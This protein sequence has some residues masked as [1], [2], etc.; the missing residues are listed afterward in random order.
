MAMVVGKN[1]GV[2]RLLG[3]R[4]QEVVVGVLEE[5]RR[6]RLG[7]SDRDHKWQLRLR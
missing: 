4:L 3:P 6:W 7:L 2:T 1:K 5:E